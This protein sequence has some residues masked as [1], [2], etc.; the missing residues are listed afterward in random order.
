MD[1]GVYYPAKSGCV[2]SK[3][4][5]T[6][7]QY[8][9]WKPFMYVHVKKSRY[10]VSVVIGLMTIAL[11]WSMIMANLTLGIPNEPSIPT[12]HALSSFVQRFCGNSSCINEL[13]IYPNVVLI[14][15]NKTDVPKECQKIQKGVVKCYLGSS[16]MGH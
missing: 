4:N 2:G 11:V 9:K 5:N 10:A 15:H 1:H 13:G 14:R 3:K 6:L 7:I 8:Q 16:F 12:Y